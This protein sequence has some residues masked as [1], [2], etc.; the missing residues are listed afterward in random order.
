MKTIPIFFSFDNNYAAQAGVTFESLLSNAKPDVLYELNVVHT[1]ISEHSQKRLLKCVDKHH[2]ATLTFINISGRFDFQFND[3][4]FS[5]GHAGAKFTTETMYRTLPTEIVEFD[6]Y[7]TIIYSDVDIVVVDDISEL[8]SI[9]LNDIYI[10]GTKAPKFLDHQFRHLGTKFSG[11]Y[12]GGGLWV[13]NLK[14]MRRD[15][16]G[17]KII[18]IIKNPP[19]RLVWNDQD[20]MNLACDLKVGYLPYKYVSIPCWYEMLHKMDYKD[21]YHDSSD[22]YEAVYNPKIIHYAASKPWVDFN[23]TLSQLWFTWLKKTEFYYD[24]ETFIKKNSPH[25]IMGIRHVNSSVHIDIFTALPFRLFKIKTKLTKTCR[26]VISIG[27]Y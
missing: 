26:L 6:K 9:D 13:M 12:V 11:H 1:E 3:E 21:D 4:S 20:V 19:C 22:L 16:L 8:Y 5:V 10:A 17:K 15:Q 24:F 23:C 2:N 18:E 25:K 14:I 7:E 27:R